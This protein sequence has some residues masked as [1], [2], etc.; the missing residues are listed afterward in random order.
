MKNRPSAVALTL[1]AFLWLAAPVGAQ[2]KIAKLEKRVQEIAAGFGGTMGVAV[3]NIKT[4]EAF[5]VNLEESFPMASTYKVPIMVEVFKQAAAGRISLD[6]RVEL[7]DAHRTYGSGILGL[8]ST[9]LKPTVRD[10]VRLMIIVSDNEATDILLEKVGAQN[11]TETM[12]SLGLRHL[13]VDRTT[14]QLILDYRALL[15][16]RLRVAEGTVAQQ[17]RAAVTA[18]RERK[19]NEEFNKIAKDTSTPADMTELLAKIYQGEVISKDACQQMLNILSTQ[20]LRTRLPRFI[21]EDARVLHKTGT[22][23]SVTNDV[24]ILLIGNHAVA[25][26]VFTKD[27]R[28]DRREVEN[29]IGDV[30]RA[31]YDYFSYLD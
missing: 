6:D 21:P 17:M 12:R 18:E 1:V 27:K 16:E 14:R 4:G 11:V 31:I 10:L 23:G 28:V 20:Q 5:G 8:L 9:G 13:R 29:A 15:D 7:T 24:G 26:S 25:V 22:I 30:G 2:P 3:K 19:A